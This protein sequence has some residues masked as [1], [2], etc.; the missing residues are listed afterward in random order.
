MRGTKRL[1]FLTATLISM[2]L[3]SACAKEEAPSVPD[4][5]EA[6]EALLRL[7]GLAGRQPEDRSDEEKDTEVDRDA[8][9]ALVKDMDA[10]DPFIADIYTGFVVGALARNQETL[11]AVVNGERGTIIAGKARVVL[12]LEDGKWRFVLGDSV[13][14]E[15]VERAREEKQKF[16]EAKARGESLR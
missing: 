14:P 9:A 6:A 11:T 3:L 12:A 8:L 13:P 2:I 7:H 16:E 5:R 4:P 1:V 10:H 15:I